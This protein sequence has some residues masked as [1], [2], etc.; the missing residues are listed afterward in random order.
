MRWRSSKRSA[1]TR[2]A[3][4]PATIPHHVR[5]WDNDGVFELSAGQIVADKY[6][7]DGVMGTGGMGVVVAAT[8]VELDQRVAI[9]FLR[10]VSPEALAR[11]QRE[12]RLLVRLKSPHVARVFDVGALDDDTPYIVMEHLDGSDLASVVSSRKKLPVEESVD[13]IL[14]AMEAVAE[15]HALGMVHRDLKPANL[16][17]ARGAGGTTTVKVLDFGVSKI[18]DDRATGAGGSP[19]GGDLT[20]E[21]MALGS[22]GYM[23][24]EQ[25]TNA[26]DVDERSDIF[27]LGALLYRCVG[28]QTPYKGN[29]VVTILASM[30]T[31]PL[32]PLRTLTPDAPETFA[33]IVERCLLQDKAARWPTVAHLANA[34]A[35]YATHRGRVSI[36]Q[37]LATLNVT[38]PDDGLAE[39]TKR[40]VKLSQPPPRAS[41]PQQ[42][43]PSA[44]AMG[45]PGLGPVMGTGP[46]FT[47]SAPAG[48][49][50][51]FVNTP[52]AMTP[53]S[54]RGL[55]QTMT[56]GITL[57]VL[58]LFAIAAG[59]R[60]FAT[61]PSAQDP[62]AATSASPGETPSPPPAVTSAA[63]SNST[64][65][66]APAPASASA[67][68]ATATPFVAPDPP[69]NTAPASPATD[70][71]RPK[72][73]APA[74][75]RSH[76]PTP[77]GAT[78]AGP[79]PAPNPADVPG[80]RH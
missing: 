44:P 53:S 63:T 52:Q 50:P 27:S 6:R 14:Q 51:M 9:K 65:T 68:I 73:T 64:I 40:P 7:I 25:M 58:A 76:A 71:P 36:E 78:P 66:A 26:R 4:G 35:P 38:F 67:P 22:P 47:V 31:E 59:W 54:R 21:G 37:I 57:S 62:R 12:A 77:R 48:A 13:Y 33:K 45:P 56:I 30:A 34:L 1:R 8:H 32:T 74:R 17:L 16:F 39:T 5:V 43:V 41:A 60:A 2:D 10:E 11:F 49:P 15:A 55:S 18:L 28:G 3:K 29:S 80:G 61:S 69:Q 20:N 70:P 19:R 24:A 79:S 23:S 46:H 72:G 75:P 42:A